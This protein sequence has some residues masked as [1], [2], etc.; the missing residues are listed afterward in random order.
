[1]KPYYDESGVQI[2][3]GDCREVLPQI[4]GDYLTRGIAMAD[5]A[6]FDPPYGCGRRYSNAYDDTPVGYWEW[7]LP[8]LDLIRS[9]VIA[10][11]HTHRAPESMRHITAHD[12]IAVWHKPYSAGARIGNSPIL[13]HW[14]PIFLY[15]IYSLGT[16]RGAIADV[17]SFNPET[18]PAKINSAAWTKGHSSPRER[19]KQENL[20]E[21][22]LPKPLG[23]MR[24]LAG[25][26]SLENETILD[27]FMG[28][29]TTLVAAK[30]LGRK[31][32]GIEIEERYCEI[33]AKRLAQGVM[34]FKPASSR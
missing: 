22:P 1:V 32:I 29:G 34:D 33:A 12:W 4:D 10:M 14:E 24:R 6:L 23:L 2:Y 13:P 15:G 9:R 3:L 8:C 7:F 21:H 31:A 17:L 5:L 11:A 18:S 25:I 27:P 20:V 16:K 19:R 28:S 26:L 30:D